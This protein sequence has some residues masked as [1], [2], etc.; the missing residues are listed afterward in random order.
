MKHKYLI[1]VV[2]VI[3]LFLSNSFL[4]QCGQPAEKSQQQQIDLRIKAVEDGLLTAIT[5]KEVPETSAGYNILA[6]MKFHKV[7]GVSVAVIKDEKIEWAKG[8]GVL[9]KSNVKK[10]NTETL[11]QAA[12]ISKPV[13]AMASLKLAEQ[14][15]I[16]LEVDAN[17]FLKS[18]KI[19]D[20]EFTKQ[21]KVTPAM[22]L[23]HSGGLTVHGFRGYAQG[24]EVPT[25]L[26]LLDGKPPANS[27]PIRVDILPNSK[28]RYSG[29]GYSVMQQM[30]IDVTGK[31]FPKAMDEL[32]LEPI[33]FKN[34]TFAQ[35]LPGKMLGNA[36]AGHRSNGEVIKGKRH[37]YPEMA[38]AGL[39]TTPSDLARFAIEIQ[40]SLKGESNNVLS[41]EMTQNMVTARL[42]KYGLGLSVRGT[43]DNIFYGHSGGN[44]G[45]RCILVAYPKSG[46]GAAIMTNADNGSKLYMEIIRSISKVYGWPNFKSREK[47]I[48]EVDPSVFKSLTGQYIISQKDFQYELEVFK[49]GGKLQVKGPEGDIE[50]IYPE[51][52]NKYFSLAGTFINFVQDEKGA[53]KELKIK[54]QGNDYVAKRK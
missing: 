28:F 7:P 20:N 31:E 10:V 1:A 53:V 37:V 48:I 29:G 13:A 15:K 49:E 40:K 42:G 26:Q 45:Y 21:K 17:T 50:R 27:K 38:A 25:L 43:G 9:E 30:I 12:S 44:E 52:K 24:E 36:T 51:G 23:N 22:M 47:T 35:P 46:M 6:R 3:T 4:W 2:V 54:H 32:V 39:W 16:D 11:F 19:P 5:V 14:G 34:S 41:K 18:W 33:D 8:Y